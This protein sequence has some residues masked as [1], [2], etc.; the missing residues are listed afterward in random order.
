MMQ[1]HHQ[2]IDVDST[3]QFASR[4]HAAQRRALLCA[5]IDAISDRAIRKSPTIRMAAK[6]QTL[7]VANNFV[8]VFFKNIN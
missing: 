2:S 8:V 1:Q 5:R 3:Q 7:M 6:H 4:K